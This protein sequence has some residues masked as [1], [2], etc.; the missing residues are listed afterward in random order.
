[1]KMI[2]KHGMLASHRRLRK[3]YRIIVHHTAGGTLSGAEGALRKRGLGYHYMIDKD[4]QVYEY[5]SPSRKM[6]HAYK[7]NTGTI[8]ISYVGGGSF[9]PI[10]EAQYRSLVE[11]CIYIKDNFKS[12]KEVTGHK[13]VDSRGWKIDPRW[14]GEPPNGIDW[15]ID[16]QEMEELAK[17]TGLTFVSKK[18]IFK[19]G[20]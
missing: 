7:A 1:M 5:G 4:G 3:P 12:V 14:P 11:L 17:R 9:G 16:R 20:Y 10:N 15:E 19:K 6:Y 8:G 18:D 2:K 13:H